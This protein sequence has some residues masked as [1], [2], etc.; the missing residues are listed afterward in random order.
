MRTVC[1]NCEANMEEN[2]I[3]GI[4]LSKK[5]LILRL[6]CHTCRNVYFLSLK[7]ENIEWSTSNERK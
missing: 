4:D 5:H 7:L 3:F 1:P 2:P 6:T